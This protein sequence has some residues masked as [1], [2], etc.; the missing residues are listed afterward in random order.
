MKEALNQTDLKLIIV[1]LK[2][3]HDSIPRR[4]QNSP[5]AGQHQQEEIRETGAKIERML[6][7]ITGVAKTK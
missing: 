4:T 1:A 7:E 5:E 3:L 2:E 6:K